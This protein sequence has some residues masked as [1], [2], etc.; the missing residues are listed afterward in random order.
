MILCK[1]EAISQIQMITEVII[2]MG[3]SLVSAS[4]MAQWVKNLPAMQETQETNV[5]SLSKKNPLEKEMATYSSTLS[6][7][8]PW[9][10]EPGRLLWGH[11]ESD[12]TEHRALSSLSRVLVKG[13]NLDTE[14]DGSEGKQHE[15][16]ERKPSISQRIHEAN[17]NI[18]KRHGFSLTTLRRNK[19]CS[20]LDFRLV[21][22][23][24]VRHL[25][26]IV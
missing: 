4:L 13:G 3:S 12:S 2:R 9:T 24:T 16:R 1:D 11:K 10:E 5:Q 6:W 7:E 25:M 19:P 22:S 23:R 21:A 26:S 18:K 15:A 17:G 14:I 20:H 8:I